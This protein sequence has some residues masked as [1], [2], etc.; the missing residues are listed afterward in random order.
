LKLAKLQSIKLKFDFIFTIWIFESIKVLT[1]LFPYFYKL[2]K[3][4]SNQFNSEYFS[5]SFVN[6]ECYSVFCLKLHISVQIHPFQLGPQIRY[7][8]KLIKCQNRNI[9]ELVFIR[10]SWMAIFVFK[11]GLKAQVGEVNVVKILK[12][13]H[14]DEDVE[15]FS[16]FDVSD[17]VWE[18]INVKKVFGFFGLEKY[19]FLFIFERIY[20]IIASMWK[21]AI[22]FNNKLFK[23][24]VIIVSCEQIFKPVNLHFSPCT[25]KLVY[26]I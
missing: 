8:S 9:H 12:N 16:L 20:N 14:V 7:L 25:L 18:N 1:V 19:V 2:A 11:S 17:G 21:S 13:P 6:R 26:R 15:F 23:N 5:L 10:V 22:I 3:F 4:F 24:H